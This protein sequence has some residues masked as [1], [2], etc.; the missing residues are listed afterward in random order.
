[1]TIP[2]ARQKK[3]ATLHSIKNVVTWSDY[4]IPSQDNIVVVKRGADFLN[5]QI[6]MLIS[7]K[8]E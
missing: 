6:E 5:R 3:N 7:D 1:M 8:I 4:M 2:H